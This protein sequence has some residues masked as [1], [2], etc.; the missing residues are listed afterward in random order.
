MARVTFE[1]KRYPLRDDETVL[2]ALLRGGATVPFSCRRGSCHNCVLRATEG[3]PGEGAVR[4]LRADMRARGYF[5]PC[6]SRPEGDLL[7]QRAD[8]SELF[9]RAMVAERAELSE[10]VV[11]LRLETETTMSWR[12]GQFVNLRRLD[13]L[14]RSYSAASIPEEDYFLELHVE[15]M[16]GGALSP[17]LCDELAV[18]DEVEIQGPHGDCFYP[19]EVEDRPILLVGTGTGLSPLVGIARD[20]LR[21]GHRAP[22]ELFHGARDSGG[23]YDVEALRQLAEAHP[24]LT[25]HPCVSGPDAPA[26]VR[27]G[28]VVDLAFDTDREGWLVFL[29]GSPE[30]VQAARVRA[31]G[32]GVR[33]ADIHADP[34]D[35]ARPFMPSDREKIEAIEA[36][37]ELWEALRGGPGLTEILTDFYGRV[38]EDARLFPFFEK[39]SV[40]KERAIAKQY[41][42]LSD[43][44]A[45]ERKFFGLRPFNAHHWMVISDELFDYR[46]ALFDDCVRRYGLAPHLA[47]RW[48]ALHESFRREIVKGAPRGLF[49]DGVEQE[50]KDW[51]ELVLSIGAVC[52]GCGAEMDVGET[53]RTHQLT[54]QLF[55]SRCAAR[56]VGASNFPSAPPVE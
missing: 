51:E 26:D 25:Y 36:D 23:L 11:R 48:A 1:G 40:T 46:E 20:A 35:D 19:E 24:E 47:R 15:R 5:L 54:G 28:R 2:D 8:L 49:L 44:F 9:V 17:W 50:L 32:A 45:G 10:R 56:K 3:D 55:C 34:F 41:E 27:T 13:G 37:P 42:F 14:T 7:V 30:V 33:R 39:H 43:L 52:D 21:A 22:I 16:A 53:G 29:C 12:A 31:V 6:K 18:G 38:Y 4:T